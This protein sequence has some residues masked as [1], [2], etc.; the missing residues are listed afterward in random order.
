MHVTAQ[1]RSH[2]FTREMC[3]QVCHPVCDIG[4]AGGVRF[5]EGILG[6]GLPIR[7]YFPGNFFRDPFI[8]A[9]IKEHRLK[10]RHIR[11]DLL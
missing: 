11:F 7:P 3:F 8:L 2:E 1:D 6:K 5:I 10:F 9:S 4:I